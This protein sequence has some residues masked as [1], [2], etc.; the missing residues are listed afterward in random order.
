MSSS[1]QTREF[2]SRNFTETK[3]FT[4]MKNKYF[5]KRMSKIAIVARRGRNEIG[6]WR[7]NR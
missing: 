5:L 3:T 1:K 4:E 2:F 6:L 7:E